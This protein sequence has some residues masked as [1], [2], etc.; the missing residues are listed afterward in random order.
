MPSVELMAAARSVRIWRQPLRLAVEC[1]AGVLRLGGNRRDKRLVLFL[2]DL[3]QQCGALIELLDKDA[4]L[5]VHAPHDLAGALFKRAGN[6]AGTLVEAGEQSRGALVEIAG[7]VGPAAFDCTRNCIG[8][9]VNAAK[10]AI[11]ALV[12]FARDS[13]RALLH[14]LGNFACTVIQ[15]PKQAVRAAVD[16]LRD[17]AGA[18][19]DCGRDV[20]D[21]AVQSADEAGRALVDAA[22]DCLR[23]L[24]D[25]LGNDGGTLV[26]PDEQ[27]CGALVQPVGQGIGAQFQALGHR[28]A[29]GFKFA[30]NR[31]RA[32]VEALEQASRALVDAIRDLVG[33]Q[34]DLAR[35]RMRDSVEAAKQV[36]R[37]GRHFIGNR[38]QTLVEAA[39]QFLRARRH[40]SRNRSEA[41]VEAT[42]KPL[43]AFLDALRECTGASFDI[44]KQ[45]LRAFFHA[46]RDHAA[47]LVE[48]AQQPLR[49]L[50]DA[51]R[52]HA[53]ALVEAA[54][55]PLRAL[56]DALR[57]GASA[58][59]EAAQ[60]PLRALVEALRDCAAALVESTQQPLRALVHPAFESARPFV[61][62]GSDEVGA[63][64]ETDKEAGRALVDF[65]GN[66]AC[67]FADLRNEFAGALLEL[68]GKR[69]R[70]LVELCGQ[71]SGA[72][73]QNAGD[74]ADPICDVVRQVGDA[75][76]DFADQRA[77]ALLDQPRNAVG[78]LR[79]AGKAEFDGRANGLVAF[80]EGT[81]QVRR[82]GPKRF[83]DPRG[84]AVDSFADPTG[85]RFQRGVLLAQFVHHLANLAGQRVSETGKALRNGV[86]DR[87]GQF[88]QHLVECLR[89][90][91]QGIDQVRATRRHVLVETVELYRKLVGM[92]AEYFQ[93]R[94]AALAH[95]GFDE[96]ETR[97]E[98]DRP[99]AQGHFYF[100]R[101]GLAR[102]ANAGS[103]R[104][105]QRGDGL[106]NHVDLLADL[107]RLFRKG[108]A[109]IVGDLRQ[110]AL[111]LL[112]GGR[113]QR[114]E[115]VSC[116]AQRRGDRVVAHAKCIAH[117][118][119]RLVDRRLDASGYE[120]E[121]VREA[122]M[123]IG[124]RLAQFV[125]VVDDLDA[126]GGEFVDEAAKPDLGIGVGAFEV[127]HLGLH[128]RFEFRSPADRPLHPVANGRDFA[129]D[130]PADRR[131][132]INGDFFRLQQPDRRF[133][134][135][136]CSYPHFLRA[137]H[138]CR[139]RPEQQDGNDHRSPD[140]R[141]RKPVHRLR[142]QQPVTRAEPVQCAAQHEPASRKQPGRPVHAA[143]RLF[144]Q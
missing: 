5:F 30:G 132:G 131:D 124:K 104:L 142:L 66:G 17:R 44:A 94:L 35:N 42:Q 49:A 32:A 63:L 115:V 47:A 34:N 77:I 110:R 121:F 78:R 76:V 96:I 113:K 43:R 56:V 102:L 12:D 3:C 143:G 1:I 86:V 112:A 50:V 36:L 60:Q 2:D 136:S 38:F 61:H 140:Q 90:H 83:L 95:I 54:Q 97:S 67:A 119:R 29:A 100:A 133:R 87:R 127:A 55:Q 11:R 85:Q 105:Q 84:A 13:G 141:K 39:Q 82:A 126:F 72:L 129:P 99:R 27:A 18:H 4:G 59:V 45:C 28:A 31:M 33:A 120:V 118:H 75:R 135:R 16:A 65:A 21:A 117:A 109:G 80:V 46:L 88:A 137:A 14:R 73:I 81:R 19:F 98:F 101:H 130:G 62:L 57:D 26:E 103:A 89:A 128:E 9:V 122:R 53:A 123:R 40:F 24:F 41:V 79:R 69:L 107:L 68:A 48:A 7:N 92:G 116:L 111:Q 25:F 139:E 93:Q 37:A 22:G 64:V 20:V 51:L 138:H 108:R 114:N 71:C 144:L 8:A 74:L 125:G 134:H 15:T 106:A 58:L 70:A 6:E 52:D 10:Q 23:P 91:A